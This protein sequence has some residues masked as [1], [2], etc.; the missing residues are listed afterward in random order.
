[1]TLRVWG[2]SLALSSFV[3]VTPRKD[4]GKQQY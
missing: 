1:M 4:E 3:M 2:M